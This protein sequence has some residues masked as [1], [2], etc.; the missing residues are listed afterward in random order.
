M[1]KLIFLNQLFNRSA[2]YGQQRQSTT[3]RLYW[4]YGGLLPSQHQ[5]NSKRHRVVQRM[6][7]HP[8]NQ[9][10]HKRQKIY[11]SIVQGAIFGNGEGVLSCP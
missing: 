10:R 6:L 7:V 2:S 8:E 5:Q 9:S 3:S 1:T 11:E 4:A